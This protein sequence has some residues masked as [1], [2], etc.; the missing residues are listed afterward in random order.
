MVLS[1]G[2]KEMDLEGELAE[3]NRENDKNHAL[4]QTV[5]QLL[6]IKEGPEG[7]PHESERWREAIPAT[8]EAKTQQDLSSAK[9]RHSVVWGNA[10]M[11]LP[12]QEGERQRIP[13]AEERTW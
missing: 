13:Q 2:W 3:G 4:A 11:C 8:W 12:H 6:I 10:S 1:F 7:R 5:A 9:I